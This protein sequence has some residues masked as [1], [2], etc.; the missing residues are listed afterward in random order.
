MDT[1][2]ELARRRKHIDDVDRQL[3]DLLNARTKVAHEIGH[4]K[5]EAGLPVLEPSREEKVLANVAEINRGPL[6]ESALRN[7]FEAI[8]KEMRKIQEDPIGP[9]GPAQDHWR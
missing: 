1:E 8:M 7:I 5:K 6:T 3:V 2:R 4:I 9:V